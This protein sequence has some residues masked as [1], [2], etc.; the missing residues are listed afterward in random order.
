VQAVIGTGKP[1][2]VITVHGGALA[3]DW[4]AAF[5]TTIVDALYPGEMGGDA[6]AAVLFGDVSPSGRTTVTWY[7][8]AFQSLRPNHTDMVLP[9]H[10]GIPGITHL[11]YTG[12]VLWPFGWG[13]SYTSFAFTWASGVPAQASVDAVAWASGITAPPPFS[14]NITNTGGVTS[15]VS[16]LAFFSSGQP[17]EPVQQL[18]DFQRVAALAPGVTTT[19][20]FTLPPAVAARVSAAGEQV[21]TPGTYHIAIGDVEGG[22]N[23]R[24]HGTVTLTGEPFTLFSMPQARAQW[25]QTRGSRRD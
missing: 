16:A 12:P 3:M 1:T 18:F 10:N 14:V 11:Y 24:V 9:P 8:T 4:T 19:V 22:P 13:L 15:D 5:A 17:G 2:V 25:A 6:V 7:P 23:G 21:V 20:Y